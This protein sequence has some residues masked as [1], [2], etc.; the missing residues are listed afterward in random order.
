MYLFAV[1]GCNGTELAVCVLAAVLLYVRKQHD[2]VFTA[3]ILESPTVHSL[4]LAV[5]TQPTSSTLT[6]V[7]KTV[8]TVQHKNSLPGEKRYL[9]EVAV[10]YFKIYVAVVTENV[11]RNNPN[12]K[13]EIHRK[14]GRYVVIK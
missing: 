12:S 2:H 10:A 4:L 3:L 8:Y 5:R 14:D 7:Y 13:L 11:D 9:S 6:T 1:Y